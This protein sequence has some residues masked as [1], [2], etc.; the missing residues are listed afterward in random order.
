MFKLKSALLCCTIAASLSSLLEE[1]VF[2]DNYN[3]ERNSRAKPHRI[4]QLSTNH[5]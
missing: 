2:E 5:E 3:S 1:L 4:L